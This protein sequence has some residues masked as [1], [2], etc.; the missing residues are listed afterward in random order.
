[1]NNKKLYNNI[2]SGISKIIKNKLYENN[3]IDI[4]QY[5]EYQPKYDFN[6]IDLKKLPK[7]LIIKLCN[8]I[9]N[10]DFDIEYYSD[11]SPKNT[12]G[13]FYIAY[14]PKND[15]DLKLLDENEISL[16][17]WVD[18]E[19]EYKKGQDGD[20][21]NFIEPIPDYYYI[22]D[23]NINSVLLTDG[24]DNTISIKDENI[25]L[26]LKDAILTN[27]DIIDIWEEEHEDD[28]EDYYE[29]D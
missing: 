20:Y 22:N 25:L 11:C 18:F 10:S 8:K 6:Y 14:D 7:K 5:V 24:N 16:D 15:A 17:F 12:N 9:L 23:V 1:M 19:F 28:Y 2:I 27:N 4:N 29:E 21:W 26:S 3:E 13:H